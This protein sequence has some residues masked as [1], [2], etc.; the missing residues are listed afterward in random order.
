MEAEFAS[1]KSNEVWELVKPPKEAPVISCKWVFKRK[2]GENGL[3]ERYKACLVA[4]GYTQ[5]PGLDDEETFSPV[6]RFESLRVALTLAAHQDLKVH[7]MGVK[8][9]FLNS[10][11]NDLIYMKQPEA[12]VKKGQGGPVCKL[13]QSIYGLKQSPR[14]W[15]SAL[16]DRLRS[17]GFVHQTKGDPCIYVA[18]E[19]EPFII[20]NY[21]D[22]ILLAG[23]KYSRSERRTNQLFQYQRS[24]SD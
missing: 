24:R 22:D 21:V 12:F 4:Q 17:I 5:R 13:K 15:N 1:L 18:E 10:E 6:M 8:T 11:L 20:A 7:Q 2:V 9:S 23:K 3:V 16:D 14:C 19:G